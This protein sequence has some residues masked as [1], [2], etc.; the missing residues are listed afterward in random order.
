MQESGVRRKP[1]PQ[2]QNAE[3]RMQ[4]T[5]VRRKPDPQE[6]NAE[7]RIQ[8]SGEKQNQTQNALVGS[9]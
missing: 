9:R 8:E 2:E 7:Y 5:G 4:E 1:D 6:Q 3:Y